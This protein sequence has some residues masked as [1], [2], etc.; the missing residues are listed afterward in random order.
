MRQRSSEVNNSFIGKESS[1][2]E[3]FGYPDKL[4][5]H[6]SIT[7]FAAVADTQQNPEHH[8]FDRVLRKFFGGKKDAEMLKRL[9]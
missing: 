3:I 9:R 1:A 4:K 8:I 5:F 7:L 6:S 2:D